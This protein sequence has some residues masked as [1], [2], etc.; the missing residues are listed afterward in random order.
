MLKWINFGKRRKL[1]RLEEYSQRLASEQFVPIEATIAY[2][3]AKLSL[4][5]QLESRV[6]SLQTLAELDY[7]TAFPLVLK[8]LVSY[9]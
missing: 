3:K 8:E 2:H 4:D 9:L 1:R 5:N 6:R 7:A